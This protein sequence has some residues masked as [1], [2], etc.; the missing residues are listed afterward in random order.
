MQ[1]NPLLFVPIVLIAALA[2]SCGDDSG[3][4][5]DY[6]NLGRIT[7]STLG[8]QGQTG[9][10]Y[11]VYVYAFDWHPGSPNDI[12][13]IVRGEINTEDFSSTAMVQSVNA[14]GEPTGQVKTFN[15]GTYSVVFFVSP[16][17]S[18]PDHFAEV[19]ATVDGDVTVTAPAWGSW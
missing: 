17:G 3:P 5:D 2:L 12:V 11:A 19:R 10:L 15:P 18:P 9:N 4:T 1:K 7:A 6:P 14:Q 13:G 16:P 8:I